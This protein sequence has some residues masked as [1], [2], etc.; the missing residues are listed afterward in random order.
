M[1]SETFWCP[2]EGHRLRVEALTPPG[3]DDSRA[4][5]VFLH[6]GLGCIRL[7]RDVP[8]RLAAATGRRAVVYDRRGYGESDPVVD[9]R[10]PDYLHIEAGRHLPALMGALEIERAVFV[11][12]S[13][14]GTI[15]LLFGARF[16]SRTAGI[17]TEAAHIYVDKMTV[18]GIR[19]AVTAYR[20]GDLRRRLARYHGE[21]TDSVFWSWAD[22]WLAPWFRNWNIEADIA[23][24][25]SPLLAIQGA[26]D[27]YGEPEQV[28]RIVKAVG[29]PAQPLIVPGCGHIPHHEAPA[30]VMA[31]V[32]AF[33]AA[34]PV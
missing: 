9:P 32:A 25:T 14:G 3:A 8:G 10:G 20:Q 28:E 6:E 11:G 15:A 18:A 33:A 17:V 16:P 7:W 19:R 31:A 23:G 22:T 1:Q 21:Q 2:V 27:P 34:L 29:G 4:P 12:H 24:V 13:D 5:L 26:D 30:A